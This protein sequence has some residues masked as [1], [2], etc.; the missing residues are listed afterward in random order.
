MNAGDESDA[1]AAAN[2]STSVTIAKAPLTVKAN[3]KSITYGEAP[4]DNGVTYTGFVNN[5]TAAVLVGAL[6]YDYTYAQYGAVSDAN[7][8]YTI[9]PKGLTSAN[10]DITFAAGTLTVLP[11]PIANVIWG[12]T[13]FIYNGNPQKPTAT[14][15]AGDLV[16]GDVCTVIVTGEQ[17][18]ANAPGES[19]TATAN[20][21]SNTNYALVVVEANGAKP[22]TQ[23]TIAK[24]DIAPTLTMADWTYGETASDPV[25][26]GNSGNGNV[27]Y[28][29]KARTA[30]DND[31]TAAKPSDVGEYTVRATIAASTN[32][33]G[34]TATANF[35]INK[36]NLPLAVSIA[37]WTYGET[38]SDPVVTG[39]T[40]NGN[41]IYEYKL[42]TASDNNYTATKPSEAGEYTVRSTIAE[43]AN[44]NEAV[45][46]ADF[47]INK[48]TIAI[49]VSMADWTFDETS[50]TPEVTGNTSNENVTFEYKARTASDN[51]YTVTKPLN[52]GDYTIRASIAESTNYKAAEATANFRINKADQAAPTGLVATAETIRGKNDGKIDNITYAME[53]GYSE[54]DADAPVGELIT[55]NPS[56]AIEDLKPGVYFFRLKGDEN[57]NP[58]PFTKVTVA[59]GNPLTVTFMEGDTVLGTS[60][61]NWNS[62]VTV[63]NEIQRDGYVATWYTDAA[64]TNKWELTTDRVTQDIT[65]YSVWTLTQTYTL[66]F[67][68]NGGSYIAPIELGAGAVIVPPE[69]PVRDGFMFTG[70]NPALPNVMPAHDLT[71][72]ATWMYMGTPHWPQP[73]IYIPP[74]NVPPS[75]DPVVPPSDDP[76]DDDDDDDDDDDEDDNDDD[77]IDQTVDSD[78]DDN[79]VDSDTDETDDIGYKIVVTIIDSPS[80]EIKNTVKNAALQINKR[81]IDGVFWDIRLYKTVNGVIT[82]EIKN[83]DKPVSVSVELPED[84]RD[85][86]D[87]YA[88]DCVLAR[89]H[90]G[91]IDFIPFTYDPD[92]CTLS[93][94]SDKF[95]DYVLMY[96]IDIDMD[97]TDSNPH[98]DSDVSGL[99]TLV[100]ISALGIL[101]LSPR[102]KRK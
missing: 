71:V 95:S 48:A 78:D 99:L 27:T 68:S 61:V 19:Y 66:T 82:E 40:I 65:L 22:T 34:D 4:A 86:L 53:Y 17:T 5:E 75:E 49:T 11:K 58:S 9:T 54:T 77:D 55:E 41:V 102:R 7:H 92:T 70:W 25:L 89:I 20:E 14:I 90:D 6:A 79:D 73:P 72:T 36:A 1:Y 91:N 18:N 96:D 50:S 52:A 85:L 42:K 100:A 62:L 33:N 13:N 60:S 43:S 64:L 12:A 98:T 57:H 35:K 21:L 24:A 59:P 16:N 23:F 32:Y 15:A 8:A 30:T 74:T 93:F 80:D 39:N 94:E 46:T 63:P 45:A 81:F 3:N 44:Y 56:S 37:D 28:E 38:A 88:D 97:N 51:D 29:Y 83:A 31:Y 87:E 101:V 84:M 2:G 67:D 76:T 69:N 47:K 10:Y 26:T